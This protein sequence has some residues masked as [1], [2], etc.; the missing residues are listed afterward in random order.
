[1]ANES[2]HQEGDFYQNLR[3]KFQKWASSEDGKK[4]KWA[5]YLIT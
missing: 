3:S 5:E 2:L 1:M 4:N